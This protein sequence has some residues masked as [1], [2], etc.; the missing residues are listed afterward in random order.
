[1]KEFRD[2]A[3]EI[4]SHNKTVLQKFVSLET[5]AKMVIWDQ[6]LQKSGLLETV[7]LGVVL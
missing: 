6:V 5:V 1:M 4:V 7:P 2:I 3:Q